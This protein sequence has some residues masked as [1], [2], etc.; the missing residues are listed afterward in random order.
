M[1]RAAAAVRSARERERSA[2]WGAWVAEVRA[3]FEG[4]DRFWSAAE[5]ALPP[6]PHRPRKERKGTLRALAVLSL[7]A[8]SLPAS[9]P[10][11]LGAQHVTL[12]VTGVRAES[13][14]ARGFDVVG[15]EPGAVVVVADPAERARLEGFG[16]RGAV[17]LPAG[18]PAERALGLQVAT[19]PRVYRNYDDPVRG[20]RAFADSLAQSNPRVT[21]D[22]IGRSFELRPMLA[23]KIGPAGDSP[24]RPNVLFLATYHA[25]EW[26]ATE[27]ALRLITFLASPPG[28]NA[29]VDSLLAARDIWVI[30]VANP[31]G[32]QYTFT[33]DR[34]WRKTRSPQGN[35]AVGVDMNRNHRQ[36]WGQDNV[37]S[38]PTPSS[39]IYR[40]LSP[41]SEVEVRNI[42]SF[43]AA[44]PPVVSV[45]Y[46][47]YA[48]L[49]L[50]P[51]GNAY[52][53]LPA[54]LP[55]YRTLAG[56]NLRSAVTDRLAG[57][58]RTFYAPSSGWMLYTTNG[59][60]NDWASAQHGTISFTPEISS[61]YTGGSYYGFEFPDDSTQLRRLFDDNLPF[62]LDVIESARDPFAYVSPTTFGHS[63]RVVLESVSPDVRV[64]VPAAAASGATIRAGSATVP[65][66]I[67][68][69]AGG[70]YTRR[71]ATL[72]GSR[73][74]TVSVSAGGQ[75]ASFSVLAY[76]GAERTE[77]GWTATQFRLDSAVFLAG[78]YSWFSGGV[79]DLR[80]PVVRVPADADTVSLLFWTRYAGS[81]F[82][83]TPF[84]Q[85]LLSTDAG[86]TFQP[87]LRLQGWAP[88]WYPERVTVGGVRNRQ[89]VFD[90]ASAGLPWHL[91]EVA[92]VTHGSVTTATAADQIALRPS[93]NPVRRGVV[94]F[95]WPFAT[96]DGDIQAFDFTGR[97]LWKATVA[98]GA[99]ASWDLRAA[100]VPNGVYVVVARSGGKTV[101][102]KLYVVRDGS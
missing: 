90:F 80:S 33:N 100:G 21:V 22:T 3:L 73:P 32:Y 72:P 54:D 39:D 19:T 38:S 89:L 30:P 27:M 5:S 36:N 92:I 60:Y 81:G 13:L 94:Y 12:R 75:T 15:T 9:L 51:P 66:R 71:L 42:E 95:T 25:R 67:D 85:L 65:F 53:Q 98:N 86:A 20:V 64:T 45:S 49:I 69:A 8:A 31:D 84:A 40:G 88:A 2:P 11:L 97:L 79:G 29:R 70:R 26:A 48:G 24:A 76:Q 68:S 58:R 43:H 96:P 62:A 47:T 99:T 6:A 50:Y 44:H 74:P 23:V 56:T 82:E 52:G 83:Q 10:A 41:A 34:L 37:G 14:L 77:T 93:E 28:V 87:V 55:V 91:D 101:R 35:G 46:H 17:L 78:R 102:L 63:D 59:E 18:A 4:A 16:W 61:G 1:E 7:G 57:S